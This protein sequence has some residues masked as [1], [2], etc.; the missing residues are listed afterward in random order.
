M[1]RLL[2]CVAVLG[3]VAPAMA[4]PQMATMQPVASPAQPYAQS[5]NAVTGQWQVGARQEGKAWQ[6]L[7]S[8]TSG[9]YTNQ[10]AAPFVGDDMHETFLGTQQLVPPPLPG[11]FPSQITELMFGYYAP[12]AYNPGVTSWTSTILIIDNPL[13][14][15]PGFGTT[16]A[17]VLVTGLPIGGWFITL[18]FQ[19]APIPKISPNMWFLVSYASLGNGGPLLTFNTGQGVGYAGNLSYGYSHDFFYKNGGLYFFGG[20]PYWADFVLGVRG[21]PEP[22]T[23]GLL[24]AGGLLALRRRR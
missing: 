13:G 10:V 2:M 12:A 20:A 5:F 8:V 7:D 15:A 24:A 19:D 6:Y 4:E 1:K 3:L 11:L 18:D 14:T 9:Y 17:S 21:V 23:I 16:V 22:M